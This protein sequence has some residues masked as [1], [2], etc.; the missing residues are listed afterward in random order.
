MR[1]EGENHKPDV[2]LLG[3]SLDTGNLGVSAL[4]A[5]TVKCI[6]M[7]QPRASIWLLEGTRVPREDVLRLAGGETVPLRKVGVRCHKRPWRREHVLRLLVTALLLRLLPVRSWRYRLT[8]CNSYLSRIVSARCVAD[9]TGGDSFSD[10]YGLRRLIFGTLNK[11]LVLASGADLVLLPQTYGPFRGRCA[12][13][14][15]RLVISRAAAVYSRDRQGLVELAAL[16]HGR[17][18]RASPRFCPDVAFMLDAI[19][20]ERVCTLPTPL[21][22]KG[23]VELIG[24]NVSGLLYNGGYTRDNMFGLRA[25][26]RS[27][28]HRIT[29]VL[30]SQ[31]RASILLIPH[32]FVPAG[33]VESDSDVCRRVFEDLV[34]RYPGRVFL[35]QGEYDQSQVKYVIGVCRFFIGSRMHACIA[36]I[37]QG[38]PAVALAYSR[39]FKGVFGSVGCEDLVVDL[40]SEDEDGVVGSLLSAYRDREATVSRLQNVAQVQEQVN[41]VFRECLVRSDAGEAALAGVVA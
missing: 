34:D 29:E 26:Y 36:A 20:P 6:R 22:E 16:T 33:H 17:R 1:S 38:V 8:R 2:I 35:L 27:L 14:L 10:I 21:P 24:M 40:R 15:A 18:M 39:K 11:L 25:D 32:V 19:P 31:T 9:I 23:T 7:Q 13:L 37:S 12:R 5:A 4:L 3:A 30:L 28:I 41:K